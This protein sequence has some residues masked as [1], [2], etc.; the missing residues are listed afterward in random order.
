MIKKRESKNWI[1]TVKTVTVDVP[2]GTMTKEPEQIAKI[3]LRRNKYPG[4]HGS[5][6]RF[7]QF[8]I[9]R[10]GSDMSEETRAKLR[11]AQQIIRNKK[12]KS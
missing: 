9:N 10:A 5:I 6:N 8:H 7:I 1:K 11:R 2:P 3:L 12:H 4:A